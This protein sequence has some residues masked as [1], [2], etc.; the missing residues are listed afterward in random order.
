MLDMHHI[1]SD[2]ASLNILLKEL[3]DIYNGKELPDLK[4]QYKDY[5][6]WQRQLIKTETVRKQKDYWLKVFSDEIPVLNLPYDYQRPPIQDFVGDRVSFRANKELTA[7]LKKLSL[8]T[9]TTLYMLLLAAYNILLAKYSGQEDIIIGSPVAGRN[10]FDLEGMV[11]VFIN[12]VAMRNKPV[13]RKTFTEFLS[14]VKENSIKAFSNQDYPFEELVGRLKLIRDLSRN[15]LFDTMFILQSSGLTELETYDFKLKA[16]EFKH[17]V[18]QFDLLLGA[19]E[20][21]D[22]ILFVFDYCTKLFNRDT[23]ERFANHFLNILIRVTENPDLKLLN[24]DLLSEEERCRLLFEFNRTKT[25]FPCDKTVHKLFEEQVERTPEKTAIVFEDKELTYR[26]LNEKSNQLARLLREKGVKSNSIVGIMINR[27]LEMII[28][29]MGIIKSGGSYLPIDP[30]F[31]ENRIKYVLNDS[32]VD[33]VITNSSLKPKV[34]T[35]SNVILIDEIKNSDF[36]TK[37]LEN[38]NKPEDLIYVIYTSGSTGNPKGVML[39]HRSVI[40]FIKGVTDKIGFSSN[41]TIISLTTISFDIFVLETLLPLVKGLKCVIANEDQQKQPKLLSEAI[42]RNKVDMLQITPSRLQLLIEYE[43][44]FNCLKLLSEIMVGGEAFPQQLLDKLKKLTKARVYN[45]YGPTETTVWSTIK[46]LTV[47][48]KVNI[49]SGIANTQLYILNADLNPVPIGVPGDLYIGGEGLATGYLNNPELTDERFIPN[50]FIENERIYKT[51]DIARWL[52]N[53]DIECLGRIDHQVKIMGHRIELEEIE[54]KLLEIEC[55]KE[56]VVT[57]RRSKKSTPYLCAYIVLSPNREISAKELRDYLLKNLPVYMV[58][59]SYSF[60][61]NIPQ[62]PNGKI[63]RKFLSEFEVEM[64]NETCILKPANEVEDKLLKICSEVLNIG[65]IGVNSNLFELGADSLSIIMIQIKTFQYNWGL[66]TQDFYRYQTIR[67][68]SEMIIEKMEESNDSRIDAVDNATDDFQKTVDDTSVVNNKES[69]IGSVLLTGATGFLGIHILCDLLSYTDLNIYCLMRDEYKEVSEER[70][71]GMLNYYFNGKYKELINERVFIV[72]GDIT[73]ERFGLQNNKYEALGQTVDIVIHAA[74]KVDHFGVYSD[75]ERVNVLGTGNVIDFSLKYNK[76]LYHISTMSVSGTYIVDKEKVKTIFTEKDFYIGQN[77]K[78]N[79]YV[80]S[81]F[82]AERLIFNAVKSG[83]KAVI[84]RVGN[85]TGRYSDG[86]F[87]I[88][89]DKN[90]FYNRIRSIIE[91]RAL[92]NEILEHSVEFTP[93]DCCSS[94]IVKTIMCNRPVPRVLHLFNNNCISLTDFI[95]ILTSLGICIET[96]DSRSY[97]DYVEG[98]SKDKSK[99]KALMGIIQD[100]NGGRELE[101]SSS[102]VTDSHITRE[103]LRKLGFH[104]PHIGTKYIHDIV[105]SITK[106]YLIM[107]N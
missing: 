70:L 93:V 33:I 25:G 53:G 44:F 58:P 38:I 39:T 48:E 86:L 1:I 9:G 56:A 11:G 96:M 97:A 73:Q 102:I 91:L 94:A 76:L 34:Y 36:S 82:E 52:N 87:Q 99:Q 50:P 60:I 66:T 68:L 35:D 79:V 10:Y 55:V 31:P 65:E 84:L 103:F 59:T 54:N 62:T 14:E 83:L 30:D 37:N 26:E 42:I 49:G 77:Y 45:M 12:T 81:K 71:K 47:C 105:D 90:A 23:V 43:D 18:S 32:N 27:S 78:D 20:E 72:N 92:P 13:G 3:V 29:I 19:V 21:K 5:S 6:E 80:R 75:Y 4:V 88:N 74:A 95:N 104:W 24:I 106:K 22:E 17:N 101:Y 8:S 15:P 57:V 41:K 16:Y 46:D 51:G 2:G 63:D 85:L 69:P 98:I 107:N 67:E 61:N 40:N 100:F 28:G 7:K 89:M 64:I